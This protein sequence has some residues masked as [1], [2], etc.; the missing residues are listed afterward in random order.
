[1]LVKID[2]DTF[3]DVFDPLY[4]EVF[5]KAETQSKVVNLQKQIAELEKQRLAMPINPS[6]AM[7]QAVNNYNA[8]NADMQLVQINAESDKLKKLLADM[9]TAE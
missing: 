1:M 8:K 6:E 9:E 7:I 3:A 4:K 5:S 2:N